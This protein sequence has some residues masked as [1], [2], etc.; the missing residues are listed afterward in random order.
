MPKTLRYAGIGPRKT[1]SE[2]LSVM[3]NL[4]AELAQ[5]GWIL[6]SGHGDGAD[7]AWASGCLPEQQEIHIPWHGFNKAPLHARKIQ[8]NDYCKNAAAKHHPAWSNLTDAAQL[9]MLRNVAIIHGHD[10]ITPVE[11]VAYWSDK[12]EGRE[13]GGTSHALRM[14]RYAGIPCFNISREEDQQSMIRLVA[15][16]EADQ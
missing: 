10:Y 13:V 14:A 8:L 1:P 6:S 7:Q 12:P 16:L 15:A 11:F 3:A 4:A 5:T 2:W 9:L